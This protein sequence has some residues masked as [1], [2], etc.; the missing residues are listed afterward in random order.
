MSKHAAPANLNTQLHEAAARN[1]ARIYGRKSPMP[2]P[3]KHRA[4]T[5]ES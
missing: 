4:A 1:L 5:E 2:A 3:G